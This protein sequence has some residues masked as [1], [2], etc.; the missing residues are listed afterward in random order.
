MLKPFNSRNILCA[1]VLAAIGYTGDL[2]AQDTSSGIR[3]RL[4]DADGNPLANATV[5]VQD[6]RT[7]ATRELESNNS[8]TFYATNLTVGGPYTVTINNSKTVTVDSIQLGDVYNLT[9]DME[10][11]EIEE[12]IVLGQ[13]NTLTDIAAGPSSTFGIFELETSVSY[14]RDIRDVYSLDPRFNMDGDSR[15]SQL[16]CI[17]KHPR[18]NSL[19][20]DGVAQNDRFG[21]NSNGYA[22]ATGMS[23]PYAAV[24]QVSAE[25]A[26]FDVTYGGF[27][28]CNVN[29]VTK[30]GTN[31][32]TGNA[33]FEG[34][35][36][37]LRGDT[38]EGADG[39]S[40][41]FSTP[42]YD[43]S[44]Y[45]F[46]VGG[47]LIKDRLFLFGAYEESEAPEFIG[48]GYA[49]S[50]NGVER[51]WLDQETYNLINTTARDKYAIDT[52]GQPS[53]GMQTTEAYVL[54]LDY[55][56]NDNHSAA[57]VYNYYDGIE[58][59]A[60]DSDQNEFEFAN[61][62]YKKSAEL[63]T[64]TAS[65]KSQWSDAF[66]TEIFINTNEMVDGQNTVGPKDVGDH[67][68][69]MNGRN[70]TIYLGADDSRQANA[71]D[72]D[73]T[74]Y[75]FTGSYLAGDHVITFGYER[76]KLNVFN[77][78]VQHSNGGEWDYYDDSLSN[79]AACAALDAQG[80]FD[81]PSCSM[82]GIDR[83][84]LGRPSRVYYG[85]G[86]GTNNASDAAAALS[87]TMNTFYIQDE[88]YLPDYNLTLVGGLRYERM[89]QNDRPQ[90]NQAFNNLVG[91]RND[92]NLD[93]VDLI[94]P[95]LGITW[96][97]DYNLTLRGG[98]GLYSGGNPMVW[99]S[100][101]WSNDGI[102]NV[103]TQWRNFSGA[104]S[105]FTDVQLSGAGRPGYD[106]PQS[107]FDTVANTSAADGNTDSLAF[108]DPD[109]EQ[110]S[111]WKYSLG[112][113]YTM[114]NGLT[115]D[116][117]IIY[118]RQN[119]PAY[120]EDV[121]QTQIGTT[122]AGAPI[123]DF[124]AGSENY[125]LTNANTYGDGL[126]VSL[127]AKQ[128][129]DWGLD[130]SLGYAYT[131]QT[132]VS[133]MTSSVASS[134]F[135]NLA[136]SSLIDPRAATSNYVSPH[137]FTA[138]ISYAREFIPGHE[139]RITAFMFSKEG[140]PQSHVMSSSDLEG[141]QRYGR[142]LLYVP[143][144]N[145]DDNVV[146]QPGFDTAGWNT[147][148]KTNGYEQYAGGFVPRNARHTRW[149]NRMDL[150]IDQELPL[151]FGT[152]AR[153]YLKIYNVLNMLNDSWGRQYDSYFYSQA[154][155]TSSVDGDG[156]YVFEN[157]RNRGLTDLRENASLYEIRL[158]V[159]FEF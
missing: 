131:D 136:L 85:S 82:S 79:P 5:V 101:A 57:L 92:A 54:K 107:V 134:N 71:L 30:S 114:D 38:L 125:M 139:T 111:E 147:F 56:I 109:Y 143:S 29:A 115:L 33:F 34:T 129:Y 103:Q 3:G 146:I 135:N 69:A 126:A 113:T 110:P 15:D 23:F 88:L 133:P 132:D 27:T 70:N 48:M 9:V 72:W 90:F 1:S 122:A 98:I 24:A 20:L 39:S 117:D 159:Q 75:K 156:R 22:T 105:V 118:S 102:S 94:M 60:S 145:G 51:S 150:R 41:S 65:L 25:L 86:G 26:P 53:D 95:R 99:V 73:S 8:G 130:W 144:P 112:A 100:N 155:V 152:Q 47:P 68:I 36:Q 28:A 21:L 46:S 128:R 83:F 14:N 64:W 108:I 55:N 66:S 2:A 138:R 77:M 67:Q 7:G 153:A 11:S 44:Y 52:G 87:N 80:R 74:F 157:F 76:D 43:E 58:D 124:V 81:D 45:G 59:R 121:S 142:H 140:Q 49:G 148:L 123:F 61:H 154:V 37:S 158:G 89:D 119:D 120:Y 13:S 40:Q 93:G 32:W 78:F 12:I 19:S 149:S 91:L 50:E 6:S 10:S 62:Y 42:D 127:I 35:N 104:Q 97:A 84:L 4:V 31:N 96:E 17:G 18:F 106:V 141:D 116:G 63:T 137:R 16:N 151:F